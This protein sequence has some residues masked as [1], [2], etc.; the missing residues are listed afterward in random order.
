MVAN[1]WGA[2]RRATIQITRCL[3]RRV[4]VVGQLTSDFDK[5]L[6]QRA[7]FEAEIHVA[8]LVRSGSVA[9]ALECRR[10]STILVLTL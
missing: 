2:K 3:N 8:K 9:V 5:T 1:W 4:H 6:R 10:P 7:K